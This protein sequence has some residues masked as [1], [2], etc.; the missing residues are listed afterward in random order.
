MKNSEPFLYKIIIIF[1]LYLIL[2]IVYLKDPS[3]GAVSYALS[4]ANAR[5]TWVADNVH[6][7]NNR[8]AGKLDF[9]YF[10]KFKSSLTA[11]PA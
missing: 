2:I 5:I 9:V 7:H 1:N 3:E 6:I 11:N 4:R 10:I 8:L